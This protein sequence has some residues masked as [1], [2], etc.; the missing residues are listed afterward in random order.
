MLKVIADQQSI[1]KYTRQFVR[2]F[3]PFID[4]QVK[5]KLGHQGASSPAKVLW[6]KKL[7]I[8]TFSRVAKDVRYWNAFGIGKPKAGALLPIT[9][10]IN[11]PWSGIDR[12]TG[13]AFAQDAWGSIFVIHRGKIGG[14]KK[15]I[16]KSFFEH[17][18]R[19]VWSFMEDGDCITRVA[20]IS[21]LNS[22]RLARETA[23]FV[24]KIE[25]LKSTVVNSSQT[26][27]NFPDVTFRKDL[28]GSLPVFEEPDI[29]AQCDHDFVVD[30]LAAHLA[31]RKLKTGNDNNHELFLLEPSGNRKSHIFQVITDAWENNIL[32]AA[33][34][35]LLLAKNDQDNPSPVLILPE[36]KAPAHAQLL[37]PLGVNVV[38]FRLEED[39]TIFHDLDKIRLDQKP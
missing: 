15:G 9:S 11:F 39:R 32:A 24:K 8:W 1:K 21:V 35:L 25:M 34:K 28:V 7:G 12:K 31:R 23:N 36:E 19:G 20:V 4:E 10:E 18:Y 38:G 6:S 37:S 33:A 14:G 17:N 5:V 29:S 13:A 22:P 2:N 3:K 16:G 27:I 26:E 30:N